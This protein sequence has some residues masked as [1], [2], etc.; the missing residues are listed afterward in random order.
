MIFRGEKTCGLYAHRSRFVK[1][2]HVDTLAE[3]DEHFALLQSEGRQLLCGLL[4]KMRRKI[5][6]RL[7]MQYLAREPSRIGT[8][9]KLHFL[10]HMSPFFDPH[11]TFIHNRWKADL[12]VVLHAQ[13]IQKNVS[14]T[15]V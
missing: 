14:D 6:K 11:R 9:A 8:M 13:H 10:Q 3:L 4:G 7:G 15:L 12:R 2:L 1:A 5:W